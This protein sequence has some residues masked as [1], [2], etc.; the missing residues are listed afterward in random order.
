MLFLNPLSLRKLIMN[1][2]PISFVNGTDSHTTTDW[3][4]NQF[5][6]KNNDRLLFR[7]ELP[8]SLVPKDQIKPM[9]KEF[10]QQ[11]FA[12]NWNSNGVFL[13][14][15]HSVITLDKINDGLTNARIYYFEES[16]LEVIINLI[17]KYESNEKRLEINW[18]YDEEGNDIRMFQIF[19]DVTRD[20]LYPNVPEGL[21]SY[22]DRYLNSSASIM[23]LI[24]EPG[25]GKTNFIRNILERIDKKVYLT[26]NDKVLESDY[27]FADFVA[28]DY[29]GSFVIEDAD[30][31]LE[32]R[33]DGNGKMSKFLNVGDGL[34]KLR[35]KKIIFSTNLPSVSN[36]DEAIMRPG[37]CFDVLEFKRLTQTQAEKVCVEYNL[38]K[39]TG[40]NSYTIAEIF[41]QQKPVV[42]RSMG[43]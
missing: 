19:D 40:Q 10:Q 38:N 36:I 9:L 3:F 12:G 37:R 29:A 27:V 24:G 26:Y 43:F 33:S 28:N 2:T 5:V 17:N 32:P 25:T 22:V 4:I 18:Y 13:H 6:L 14:S 15:K 39:V 30:N 23:I 20:S 16:H 7:E 42:K 11:G 34:V 41:N 1:N 35:G 21:D 8:K 31:I